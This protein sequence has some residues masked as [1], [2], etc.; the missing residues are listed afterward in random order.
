MYFEWML[1][2]CLIHWLVN[3]A[4]TP[5]KTIWKRWIKYVSLVH[6]SWSKLLLWMM[7]DKNSSNVT[8]DNI[9][10][11]Q[12]CENIFRSAQN[13]GEAENL[14][15]CFYLYRY[16]CQY[17]PLRIKVSQVLY[18]Y[19][20]YHRNSS[21]GILSIFYLYYNIYIY[22]N[23]TQSLRKFLIPWPDNT[24]GRTPS[25]VYTERAYE[26]T[27]LPASISYFLVLSAI[28]IMFWIRSIDVCDFLLLLIPWLMKSQRRKIYRIL[29]SGQELFSVSIP[30]LWLAYT[31]H[32]S[33]IF[34]IILF[35]YISYLVFT[36]QSWSC[37]FS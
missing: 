36:C 26:I 21:F 31:S 28:S 7:A 24:T 13:N 27:Q 17:F 6:V 25:M 12:T 19:Y 9:F 4:A 34:C 23:M 8:R 20:Y 14:F 2:S 30:V 11:R 10:N 32:Y 15:R 3:P 5:L 29:Y 18:H 16:W 1:Y 22:Y 35:G 37:L 33:T